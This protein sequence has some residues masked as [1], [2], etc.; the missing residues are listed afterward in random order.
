MTMTKKYHPNYVKSVIDTMF[1]EW[2][3]E[4]DLN[5][6]H[7]VLGATLETDEGV[8]VSCLIDHNNES[9]MTEIARQ[10]LDQ[11]LISDRNNTIYLFIQVETEKANNYQSYFPN[12]KIDPT[13]TDY[14]FRLQKW[15]MAVNGLKHLSLNTKEAS[16][17]LGVTLAT[18]YR[19]VSKGDIPATKRLK[20]LY[21]NFAELINCGVKK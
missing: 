9:K 5:E 11:Y 20:R 6:T 16:E 12:Y 2:V 4:S 3:K 8:Y 15:I 10:K 21:F 17:F 1:T 7:N 13:E 19:K 18:M 14:Y